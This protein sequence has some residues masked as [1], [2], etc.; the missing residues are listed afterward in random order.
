MMP[1]GGLSMR[2]FRFQG[3][4]PDNDNRRSNEMRTNPKWLVGVMVV[5]FLAA[6]AIH[7]QMQFN[8][9][10]QQALYNPLVGG[11][12]ILIVLCPVAA[13]VL[14]GRQGEPSSD[15][16]R[17]MVAVLVG[18]LFTSLF[19][20]FA[21]LVG[22]YRGPSFAAPILVQA[23]VYSVTLMLTILLLLL[24]YRWMATHHRRLALGVYALAVVLLA[25]ATILGDQAMLTS[26]G[27]IFANGYTI[28]SDVLY[29]LVIYGLPFGVYHLPR[30]SGIS[31]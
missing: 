31:S 29:A 4:P 19:Q 14:W 30:R 16:K 15:R 2:D 21:V 12:A 22:W 9:A 24:F 25:L 1:K 28:A 13:W 26:G 10:F 8:P 6:G 18:W 27:F 11:L 23:F 20:G 7:G 5:G 17:L 3:K